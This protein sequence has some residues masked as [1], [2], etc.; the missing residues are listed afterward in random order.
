LAC[1]EVTAGHVTVARLVTRGVPEPATLSTVIVNE[2]EVP[3]CSP[4]ITAKVVWLPSTRT[5][6][7]VTVTLRQPGLAVMV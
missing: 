5:S 7:P 4:S 2:Y 6:R 1:P 3:A